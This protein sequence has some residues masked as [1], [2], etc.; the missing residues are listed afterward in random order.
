MKICDSDPVT[1]GHRF[2]R[3]DIGILN[4]GLKI[5]G[6]KTFDSNVV[7]PDNSENLAPDFKGFILSGTS[8]FDLRKLKTPCFE[9]SNIHYSVLMF[10]GYN[11]ITVCSREMHEGCASGNF[12]NRYI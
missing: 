3:H 7:L 10:Y 12:G 11:Q 5:V 4:G 1:A 2:G 9:K 6:I 8:P